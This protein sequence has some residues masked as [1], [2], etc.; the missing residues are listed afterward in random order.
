MASVTAL[1]VIALLVVLF[2]KFVIFPSFISPLSK[3]PN[4]HFTS[5]I[6]PIWIWWKRREGVEVRTIYS[7]HQK[8]GPVVRLGP[9]ELSVNSAGGLRTIYTGGFEKHPWYH[10]VFLNYGTENLVSM[11]AY[12]PHSA[13]KRMLSNVYSKSYLQNSP[14]LQIISSAIVLDRLLPLLEGLALTGKPMNVLPLMQAVGM[15]FMSAYL[16]GMAIGTDFIRDV[17]YRD[18]WLACYE[19]FKNQHP[20]ERALG[21]IERWCLLLCEKTAAW[22]RARAEKRDR[23][24]SDKFVTNPVVY[25]QLSQCLEKTPHE[26]LSGPEHLVIASEMLDHLVAGHETTGITFTYL[27]WEMSQ[28]PELQARLRQEL[29]TLSPPLKYPTP[30]DSIEGDLSRLPPAHAI[31]SLPLLNAVLLETLRLHAAVPGLQPRVTPFSSTPTIIEGYENIPGGVKVSSSAYTLHRNPDIYLEPL[32]WIPERWMEVESGK[33]ED[34]RRLL[35]AF[36]SGRRMC[37]GSNFA[38]QEIKLVIAAIYTNYTTV[39]VDDEG[40]EQEDAYIAPPKS[41][42]LILEFRRI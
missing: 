3:I 42:K 39:I 22:E 11:L 6:L 15:D 31:D 18:R 7:L 13:R 8:H 41:R 23:V 5:P 1:A 12:K 38:L 9:N 14:D 21:E 34:M 35:W 16:F 27:M 33:A 2:Y 28:R 36:G 26:S 40:I 20:R 24:Y 30:L 32:A 19:T 29:L 10:G 4:A 25:R 37:L 17:G